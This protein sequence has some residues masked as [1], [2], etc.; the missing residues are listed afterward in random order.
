MSEQG[1]SLARQENL[2]VL[3][4]LGNQITYAG[5][6]H[7]MSTCVHVMKPHVHVGNHESHKI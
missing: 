2:L 4:V 3:D 5:R 7:C 6:L 1:K